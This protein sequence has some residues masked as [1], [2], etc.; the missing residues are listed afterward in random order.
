MQAPLVGGPG[1]GALLGF[2]TESQF[3]ELD[4][5]HVARPEP[6]G[7]RVGN[8]HVLRPR[9]ARIELRQEADGAAGRSQ[10]RRQH[11]G[12][13]AALEVPRRHPD[14]SRERTAGT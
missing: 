9:H 1:S 7:D 4:A 8:V 12:S 5:E 14:P 10:P 2:V 6:A 13:A 3:H 11:L